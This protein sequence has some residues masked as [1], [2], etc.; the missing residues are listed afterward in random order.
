MSALL[1]A[2]FHAL[3]PLWEMSLTA[4]YATAVVVLLRLIL[5]KRAPKQVLC[6]L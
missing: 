1:N 5:K 3:S 2:L 4:A 6:V